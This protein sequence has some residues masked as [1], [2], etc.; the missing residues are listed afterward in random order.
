MKCYTHPFNFLSANGV[1]K[2]SEN[3]G[4]YIGYIKNTLLCKVLLPVL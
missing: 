2:L 1:R 4:Y 3:F